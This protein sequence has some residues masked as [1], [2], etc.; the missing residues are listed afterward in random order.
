MWARTSGRVVRAEGPDPSRVVASHGHTIPRLVTKAATRAA[1]SV[2]PDN[3]RRARA[4]NAP[5]SSCPR[6]A[7]HTPTL[8]AMTTDRA[9]ALTTR[10]PIVSLNAVGEVMH[11]SQIVMQPNALHFSS[12]AL[13]RPPPTI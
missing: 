7:C 8:L 10:S 2:A 13:L 6:R 4:A 1:T 5:A 12:E 3:R 9:A 11:D